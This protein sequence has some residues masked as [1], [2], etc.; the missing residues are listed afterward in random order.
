M[1][2][3]VL[4]SIAVLSVLTV[5]AQDA[6]PVVT[7]IQTA[8]A[9]NGAILVSWKLGEKV[10]K[11]IK[12][13]LLYRSTGSRIDSVNSAGTENAK[14]SVAE[15]IAVLSPEDRSY[16]DFNI[17]KGTDYYYA[18]LAR[19]EK[20]AV[21]DLLIPAANTTISPIAL[22]AAAADT[23]HPQT[24]LSEDVPQ[25]PHK[26][27]DAAARSGIREQPLP[28][29]RLFSQTES[30]PLAEKNTD[31][32]SAGFEAPRDF[33]QKRAADILPQEKTDAE[34]T[35]D[36]YSLFAIVD[37]YVKTKNWKAAE[38]ELIQFLQINRTDETTARANFY[39]GQSYY[40]SG[41]YREALNCFQN[42]RRLYPVQSKRWS[43]RV[44]DA[45]RID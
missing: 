42:A 45:Y 10:R 25:A 37:A 24:L 44:L 38:K 40:F 9:E 18:V 4:L 15:N 33:T 29:L 32:F 16:A 30:D 3:T 36:D 14:N 26:E 27:T 41:K 2:R 17:Q 39:L 11:E 34:S 7:D 8:L 22:P 23:D 28:T 20:G 21:Y 1:K 31:D 13:L 5:F 19:D 6:R 35:G 12:E 43:T